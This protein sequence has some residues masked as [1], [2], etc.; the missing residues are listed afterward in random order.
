M[1]NGLRSPPRTGEFVSALVLTSR[2]FR[3]PHGLMSTIVSCVPEPLAAKDGDL[4]RAVVASPHGW[5]LKLMEREGPA[6]TRMLWRMLGR[7]V[8]VLDAY[9]DCFCKLA[10]CRTARSARKARAYLYRTASN[11]AIEVLRKRKCRQKHWPAVVQACEARPVRE[12]VCEDDNERFSELRE[13][14]HRL[15]PHMRNVLMLREFGG[16]SYREVARTLGIDHATARVYR[17][18][19]VVKLGRMMVEGVGHE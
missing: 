11:V 6:L 19:A 10:T 18:A 9:Q 2:L 5:V 15:P 3:R 16:L 14:I 8:D 12:P 4:D 1:Y 7:E 13:A 17:R